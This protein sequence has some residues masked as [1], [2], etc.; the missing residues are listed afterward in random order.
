METSF[1]G[2][3]VLVAVCVGGLVT[4]A[5]LLAAPFAQAC[6]PGQLEDTVTRMCWSQAGPGDTRGGPE[7]APCLPGRVGNCL[8]SLAKSSTPGAGGN[9]AVPCGFG[10]DSGYPCGY[11]P[12]PRDPH[13]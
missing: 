2:N 13:W 9:A 11:W 10:P 3:R 1:A 12:D 8:G 4:A 5:Q 6:P 7:G